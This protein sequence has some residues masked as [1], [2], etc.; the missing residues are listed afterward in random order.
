[1]IY[2]GPRHAPDERIC[3]RKRPHLIIPAIFTDGL[4]L[5]EW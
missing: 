2:S 1:M 4:A 3:D 5:P